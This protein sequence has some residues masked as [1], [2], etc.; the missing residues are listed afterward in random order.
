MPSKPQL[1]ESC[2]ACKFRSHEFF[3]DLPSTALE[4][5]EGIKR[6]SEHPAGAFLFMEGQAPRGVF[7]LC[8]GR[9]KIYMTSAL[10]KLL[11]LKSAEAGEI[12]GLHATISGRPYDATTEVQEPSRM[13]FV[14]RGD[15]LRFLREHAEACLRAAQQLS[16]SCKDAYEQV[17][18][19]GLAHTAAEKLARLLLEWSENGQQTPLGIRVEVQHTQ[20]E[21]AQIIG[22][23]RETVNRLFGKLGQESLIQVHGS[24]LLIRDRSALA[25]L[26]N[27]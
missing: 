26:V 8:Q 24:I 27:T 19:I 18:S 15:F 22:T 12:L 20:E 21:I 9:V 14:A 7:L 4:A 10:G 1:S 5:F 3:C 25:N 6:Q 16:D 17:R 11:L 13:A 2:V 23:S